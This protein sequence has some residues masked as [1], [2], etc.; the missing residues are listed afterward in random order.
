M[1]EIIN[2]RTARKAR[3]RAEAETAAARNR[4]IH[5]RTKAQ[6]LSQAAELARE[7]RRLEHARREQSPPEE[8][9]D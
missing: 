5:G 6:K 9:V 2:L 7:A 3:A 4:V 8:G 1:A